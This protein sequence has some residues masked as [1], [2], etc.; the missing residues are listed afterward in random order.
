MCEKA[1]KAKRLPHF[2][3]ATKDGRYQM[4]I[5][6]RMRLMASEG[7]VKMENSST[8]F[9]EVS[10]PRWLTGSMDVDV[11]FNFPFS[12]NGCSSKNYTNVNGINLNKSTFPCNNFS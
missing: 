8:P 1:Q 2:A 3:N 6:L 9:G 7:D 4:R 5:C 11:F 12:Y 10:L